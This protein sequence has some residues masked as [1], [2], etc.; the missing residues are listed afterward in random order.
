MSSRLVPRPSSLPTSSTRATRSSIPGPSHTLPFAIPIVNRF[1]LPDPP[2]SPFLSTSSSRSISS[3]SSFTSSPPSLLSFSP[4]ASFPR[5]SFPSSY[6]GLV[7]RVCL[8]PLIFHR[9]LR[10]RSVSCLARARARASLATF[11]LTDL[12]PLKIAPGQRNSLRKTKAN[13]RKTKKQEIKIV[14]RLGKKSQK[15]GFFFV[16]GATHRSD[17]LLRRQHQQQLHSTTHIYAHRIYHFGL[18][19]HRLPLYF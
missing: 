4:S 6:F 1:F 12:G 11:I 3:T 8:P 13:N 7:F 18:D 10:L 5:F 9:H 14:Y 2:L 19:L 16:L 15:V 17:I